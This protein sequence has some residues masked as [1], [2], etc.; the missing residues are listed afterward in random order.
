MRK[1]ARFVFETA[2]GPFVAWCCTALLLFAAYA[3]SPPLGRFGT[4][5]VNMMFVVQVLSAI[6]WLVALFISLNER[7]WIGG[8][9]GDAVERELHARIQPPKHAVLGVVGVTVDVALQIQIVNGRLI[10]VF[11]LA[12]IGEMV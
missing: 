3:I 8:L 6:V 4:A 7:E 11:R 12:V 10:G 2:Y 1:I 5:L 9:F